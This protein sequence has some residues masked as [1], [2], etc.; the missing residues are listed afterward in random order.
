VGLPYDV[1]KNSKEL[2][3]TL[4]NKEKLTLRALN[5]EFR[6]KFRL[7]RNGYDE[8]DLS[9]DESDALHKLNTAKYPYSNNYEFALD[10]VLLKN[11]S[12]QMACDLMKEGLLQIT[13][14]SFKN[15]NKRGFRVL[16]NAVRH[17]PIVQFSS[18]DEGYTAELARLLPE[19]SHIEWIGVSHG[20]KSRE[21]RQALKE[22]IKKNKGLETLYLRDG[23]VDE[24]GVLGMVEELKNNSSV[25]HIDLC[26]NNVTGRGATACT[27]MLKQN[28]TL[29]D[30]D[31][32]GNK[33]VFKDL[34][35]MQKDLEENKTLVRIC[36]G[37]NKFYDYGD[38]QYQNTINQVREICKK[39]PRI[40]Q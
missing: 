26:G 31:L 25:T 22:I 33:L 11:P 8:F 7:V 2:D 5:N 30:L 17:T 23:N 36:I 15:K 28:K 13:G 21:D 27:K 14:F 10:N 40:Y 35:E 32:Y 1:T 34:V 12:S 24:E 38:P 18:L 6:K 19:N 37:G 9:I 39:D 3:Y 20:P 16:I 4:G 29:K